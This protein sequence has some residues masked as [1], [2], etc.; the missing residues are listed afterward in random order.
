MMMKRT[1]PYMLLTCVVALLAGGCRSGEPEAQTTSAEID[2]PEIIGGTD[3]VFAAVPREDL[4]S[5]RIY[6]TLTDHE[7]YARG[8][9]LMH[10]NVAFHAAGMPVGA[11]VDQMEHVGDYQGVEYYHRPGDARQAL[12]VPVY[13]GYWQPFRADTSTRAGT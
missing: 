9:P 13:E 2:A 3:T 4:P 5:S 8:E 1:N 10:D 11:S 7:W 12:Y 6:Y